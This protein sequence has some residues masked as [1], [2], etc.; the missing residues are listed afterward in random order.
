M[1][2][3]VQ[4]SLPKIKVPTDNLLRNIALLFIVVLSKRHGTMER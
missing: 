3:Y 4:G 1:F 2:L